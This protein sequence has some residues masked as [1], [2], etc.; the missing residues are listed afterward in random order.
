MKSA[1]LLTLM[2]NISVAKA[3]EI[4][5]GDSHQAVNIMNTSIEERSEESAL[6]TKI[7]SSISQESSDSFR[8]MVVTREVFYES[9][10]LR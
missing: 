1:F 10:H 6:T 5:K 4:T 9:R 2:M 3:M 8:K 7:D